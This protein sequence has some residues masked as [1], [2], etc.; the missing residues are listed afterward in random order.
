MSNMTMLVLMLKLL[1]AMTLII[2]VDSMMN[3]S[4]GSG[5]SKMILPNFNGEKNHSVFGG[6]FKAFYTV[7]RIAATI[8]RKASDKLPAKE[9]VGTNDT[10]G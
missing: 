8:G 5:Q 1:V 10:D 9:E 3:S 4:D 2:C 7:A 6:R